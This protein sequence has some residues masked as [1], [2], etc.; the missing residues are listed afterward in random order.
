MTCGILECTVKARSHLN[1]MEFSIVEDQIQTSPLRPDKV[2]YRWTGQFSSRKPLD[3]QMTCGRRTL[4][5]QDLGEVM[6]RSDDEVRV[7]INFP[8]LRIALSLIWFGALLYLASIRLA[9]MS[10]FRVPQS[11]DQPPKPNK[12]SDTVVDLINYWPAP[13]GFL[14]GQLLQ[15]S[16]CASAPPGPLSARL[17]RI[18]RTQPLRACCIV[19]HGVRLRLQHLVQLSPS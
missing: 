15:V 1:T 14:L 9:W 19:D 7:P 5:G 4:T 2:S 3:Y 6:F 8:I 16:A 13:F 12:P 17:R 10:F 11:V 18:H